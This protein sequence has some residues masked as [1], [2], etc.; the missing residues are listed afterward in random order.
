MVSRRVSTATSGV[1]RGAAA[2]AISTTVF[3][4]LHHVFISPIWWMFP[5]M[6]V[7]GAACGACLVWCFS[8]LV[9]EPSLKSW[10]GYVVLFT[11]MF[12][13]LAVTSVVIYE[14]IIT[15]TEMLDSTGGNPIPIR[16]TI[17]LMT[18]FTLAWSGGLVWLYRKG[19]R[20]FG[21]ALAAT[22]VLMLFLGFN[23]STVG[24]VE[25]PTEARALMAS[26]FG[27]IIAL[28]LVFGA[29]FA[30]LPRRRS[31]RTAP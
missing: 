4:A 13:L 11:V 19:W 24:L 10:V 26:F 8:E 31:S 27:Y 16:E 5:V 18:V 17:G 6:L 15:M 28:G 9:D 20:E 7:A 14:P 3:T 1:G 2:G 12:G 25:F 29:A 22:T 21:I 30:L 23:V